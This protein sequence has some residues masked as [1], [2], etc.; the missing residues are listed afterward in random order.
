[1]VG[2]GAFRDSDC[3][4]KLKQ[5]VPTHVKKVAVNKTGV[6]VAASAP[7]TASE[8]LLTYTCCTYTLNFV[9]HSQHHCKKIIHTYKFGKS[10][11]RIPYKFSEK[12]P[13]KRDQR[14]L[15]SART[16]VLTQRA[17]N[18]T[19]TKSLASPHPQP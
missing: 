19:N 5:C 6:T 8:H 11:I 13:T 2:K 9:S 15:E 10:Y 16:Q 18:S 7:C 4:V 3:S 12:N 14:E 1:M 17:P